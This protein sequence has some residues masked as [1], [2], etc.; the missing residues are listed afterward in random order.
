MILEQARK[1]LMEIIDNLDIQDREITITC[2]TLTPKRPSE[3]RFTTTIPSNWAKRGSSRPISWAER[4]RPFQ[5]P[6]ST[7]AARSATCSL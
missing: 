3:I 1:Q 5:I 4:D 2:K 7:T 6:V